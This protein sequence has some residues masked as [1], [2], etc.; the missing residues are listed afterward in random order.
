MCQLFQPPAAVAAFRRSPIPEQLG[1]SPSPQPCLRDLGPAAPNEAP[2]V[3]DLAAPRR[4]QT[5]LMLGNLPAGVSRQQFCWG[6]GLKLASARISLSP[7]LWHRAE[8]ALD[9][10]SAR[11]CLVGFLHVHFCRRV[12]CKGGGGE[13]KS[14]R[15]ELAPAPALRTRRFV[16]QI[17]GLRGCRAGQGAP[18]EVQKPPQGGHGAWF[19][20]S[21][22][23]EQ[24]RARGKDAEA[25]FFF[26]G[27]PQPGSICREVLFHSACS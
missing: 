11:F 8:P 9:L 7:G 22:P 18:G 23:Q 12:I 27:S 4:A 17:L 20:A 3:A 1:A 5:L 24:R 25:D 10:H 21:I 6:G 15:Q 19:A 13:V 16:A 26:F 14:G 2:K